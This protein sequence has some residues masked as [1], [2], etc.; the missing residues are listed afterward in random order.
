MELRDATGKVRRKFQNVCLHEIAHEIGRLGEEYIPY[1]TVPF[2]PLDNF[3]N[4]VR[5]EEMSVPWWKELAETNETNAEGN[6][7]AIHDCTEESC[8]HDHNC[9]SPQAPFSDSKLG[10][11]WGAQYAD[12]N[13]DTDDYDQSDCPYYSSPAAKDFFRSMAS[14]KMKHVDWDF[15][16]VCRHLLTKA[17]VQDIES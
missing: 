5:R 13:L 1:Q 16:R 8:S 7:L 9:A 12:Y 3:E 17:I 14:C 10:L 2:D 6:F 4:I 11:F 15:C